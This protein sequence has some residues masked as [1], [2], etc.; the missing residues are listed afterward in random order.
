MR[1]IHDVTWLP[2]IVNPLLNKSW[3]IIWASS[4]MSSEFQAGLLV[5]SA[6]QMTGAGWAWIKL[7]VCSVFCCDMIELA[8]NAW[9]VAVTFLRRDDVTLLGNAW[10]WH[11][12]GSGD[13]ALLGNACWCNSDVILLGN[14]TLLGNTGDRF[15]GGVALLL[16]AAEVWRG[17]LTLLSNTLLLG[18]AWG[19]WGDAWGCWGD[20]CRWR[21]DAWRCWGDAWVS[22]RC[23]DAVVGCSGNAWVGRGIRGG[24]RDPRVIWSSKG[25]M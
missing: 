13:V 7:D 9:R 1:A 24:S 16:N 19:C 20:T 2:N 17:I 4:Y 21:G 8:G 18:N 23:G 14:V 25:G 12:G 6:T 15:R 3:L 10:V 22:P 11:V 5:F